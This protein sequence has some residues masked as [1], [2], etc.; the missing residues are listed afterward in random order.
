[1]PQD[2][3][4]RR[5]RKCERQ[6]APND[7]PLTCRDRRTARRGRAGNRPIS[8]SDLVRG[9]QFSLPNVRGGLPHEA[10]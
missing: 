7:L 8:Y 1:M 3:I 2:T 9:I 5:L 6:Y 4:E 10:K